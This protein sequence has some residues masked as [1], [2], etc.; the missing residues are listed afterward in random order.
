MTTL[1]TRKGH[2]LGSIATA[3]CEQTLPSRLLSLRDVMLRRS[4]GP[5]QPV[6]GNGWERKRLYRS[7]LVR[8]KRIFRDK[9]LSA[10]RRSFV[11]GRVERKK[12]KR[13][14]A[15]CCLLP[16]LFLAK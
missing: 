13:V 9:I 10:A 7:R 6:G 3:P 4:G 2:F 16:S 5:R 1:A 8:G 14:G 15:Y 11:V 12:S